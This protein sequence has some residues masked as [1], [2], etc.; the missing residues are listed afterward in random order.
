M[1]NIRDRL[2]EWIIPDFNMRI[3][4]SYWGWK[5]VAGYG[6]LSHEWLD[7]IVQCDGGGKA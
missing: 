4:D 7:N 3:D 2:Y 1:M 6:V 5:W